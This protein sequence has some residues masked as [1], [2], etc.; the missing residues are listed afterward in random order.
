MND[1]ALA[2]VLIELERSLLRPRVRA[3][4]QRLERLLDEDFLEFGAS[5]RVFAREAILRAL[6]AET[7]SERI[8]ADGF[9]V[10]QLAPGIAQVTYRSLSRHDGVARPAWRCSLWRQSACGWRLFFHQ[11]TPAAEQAEDPKPG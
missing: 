11:G 9:Q 5:G 2:S 10:R 7:G 3:D 6:P 4:R 8:E 1:E